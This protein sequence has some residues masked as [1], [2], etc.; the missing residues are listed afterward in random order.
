MRGRATRQ[1]AQPAHPGR[2]RRAAVPGDRLLPGVDL[3]TVL[4][5]AVA[6]RR[7]QRITDVL[8]L[9][10]LP[11]WL[12][13]GLGLLLGWLVVTIER[14][15]TSYSV[16]A[17]KLRRSVFDA[18]QA[19]EPRSEK[20]RRRIADIAARDRG[21]VTVYPGYEPFLGFGGQEKEWSFVA[22]LTKPAPGESVRRF[23]IAEIHDHVAAAVSSLNLP[24]VTVD[25][26]LFAAGD[27]LL[28]GSMPAVAADLLPDPL[29]P[30]RQQ[31][32]GTVIRQQWDNPH[33]RARPY[34]ALRITGW[35]GELVM[36]MFVR[37]AK[38]RDEQLYTE[39]EYRLLGPMRK[40]YHA[41]DDLREHPSFR[42]V[43]RII[44]AA[45][46]VALIRQ[47]SSPFVVINELFRPL[48]L[49]S[50]ARRERR[51]ITE[52]RTF[53][54]GAPISA[55]EMA[56]DTRY[57]RHFQAADKELYLKIIE[58]KVLDS[59]EEFFG[60]H[61]IDSSDIRERQNMILNLGLMATGNA[62]IKADNMAVGMNA[63]ATAMM[64]KVTGGAGKG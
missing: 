2:H 33:D 24:G 12:L 39:A 51:E 1:L 57:H 44:S 56:M 34:L 13:F 29:S 9:L 6:A 63:K 48:T 59:I 20:M 15:R 18:A 50:T 49:S 37:F 28:N 58:R 64:S 3:A 4:K 23:G 21:N 61:G 35:S 11:L 62:Q 41:V 47:I 31:V 45:L 32:G 27:D 30:P 40:A 8:L 38:Y 53:N 36:T 54:Y 26:R 43:G 16:L 14:L 46:P 5:Y 25:D 42:Q 17:P 22:D 10:F 60:A 19:P 55:R 52:D 7:R